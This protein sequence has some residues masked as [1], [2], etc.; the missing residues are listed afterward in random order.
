MST[1]LINYVNKN[2]NYEICY[3]RIRNRKNLSGRG[4][5]RQGCVW[6]G[7]CPSGKCPS[8]KRPSGKSSSGKCLVGE[9]SVEEVSVGE[10]S[11]VGVSVREVS[12][13]GNVRRGNVS[14]GTVRTPLLLGKG[15]LEICSKFTG[16]H[17]CRSAISIKLQSN[18]I[19]ITR[20]HGCSPVFSAYF[21][22]TFP[23]NT[24]GW[25]VLSTTP[26]SNQYLGYG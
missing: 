22:I 9:M 3:N 5:V 2:Y 25:L 21:R 19:K 7:K 20:W 8:G 6:S 26:Y 16:E 11:V 14:R 23:K 4:S 15:V 10:V 24:S 1:K 13:L 18:F 17:P 12:V